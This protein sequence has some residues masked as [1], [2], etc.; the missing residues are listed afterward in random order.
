MTAAAIL[1]IFFSL[2]VIVAIVGLL[3]WEIVKDK[4]MALALAR[5][6]RRRARA[7]YSSRHEIRRVPGY[8]H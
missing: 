1:N 2:F 3:G 6:E 7:R 5:R 4:R 8:S